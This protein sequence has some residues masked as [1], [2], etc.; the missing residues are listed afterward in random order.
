MTP[1]IPDTTV[2]SHTPSLLPWDNNDIL[3][4]SVNIITDD[5]DKH[6]GS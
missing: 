5:D 1:D 2:I 3:N 4:S 6:N